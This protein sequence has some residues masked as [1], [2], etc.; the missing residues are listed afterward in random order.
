MI[1]EFDVRL[2]SDKNSL[3]LLFPTATK[4]IPKNLSEIESKLI[5]QNYAESFEFSK[6]IGI[7]SVGDWNRIVISNPEHLRELIL[8]MNMHH[9]QQISIIVNKIAGTTNIYNSKQ[10]R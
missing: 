3:L 1:K 4:P 10:N 8:T 2:S 5:L 6:I 9:E 7:K